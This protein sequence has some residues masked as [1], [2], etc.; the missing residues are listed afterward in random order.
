MMEVVNGKDDI[1][2]MKWKIKAMFQTTNQ[3]CKSPNMS[4]DKC[5]EGPPGIAVAKLMASHNIYPRQTAES[6]IK[7]G[8]KPTKLGIHIF[9]LV[10]STPLKNISQ[11]GW[12]FPIYGKIKMFQTTNP[13]YIE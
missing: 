13:Y 9:W 5:P 3:F 7:K 10:V 2:Y 11:L 8:I 1:P 6:D 4:C 12:L